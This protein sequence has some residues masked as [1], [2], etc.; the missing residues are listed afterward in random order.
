M[1]LYFNFSNDVNSAT[2]LSLIIFLNQKICSDEIGSIFLSPFSKGIT[3]IFW[4]LCPFLCCLPRHVN[5]KTLYSNGSSGL[6]PFH[7]NTQSLQNPR[8]ALISCGWQ[9]LCF[10]GDLLRLKQ[11]LHQLL[12]KGQHCREREGAGNK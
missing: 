12:D 3:H 4:N 5:T 11:A 8:P 10:Q 9:P 1:A 2:K 7:T 6:H